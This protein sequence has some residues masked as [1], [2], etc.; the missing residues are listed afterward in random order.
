MTKR[1]VARIAPREKATKGSGKSSSKGHEKDSSS[2]SSSSDAEEE[3]ECGVCKN[4]GWYWCKPCGS[5]G[6]NHCQR[7]KD[8]GRITCEDCEGCGML[9]SY[10]E[11]VVVHSNHKWE[12][13]WS[14]AESP[15]TIQELRESSGPLMCFQ[16][17]WVEE[18]FRRANVAFD[19]KNALIEL[20][21]QGTRN[22]VGKDEYLHMQKPGH[23]SGCCLIWWFGLPNIPAKRKPTAGILPGFPI[24]KLEV[25]QIPSCKVLAAWRGKEFSFSVFGE[26]MSVS[27]EEYPEQCCGCCVIQ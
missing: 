21:Q 14:A 6:W 9:L 1:A 19:P 8:S 24:R 12:K 22:G 7:C 17:K 18:E 20:I 4:S 13:K 10:S 11:L 5:K 27:A 15:V 16:A 26:E 2:S 23:C 3:E 25:K